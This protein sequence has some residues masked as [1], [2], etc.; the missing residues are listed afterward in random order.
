MKEMIYMDNAATTPVA[1]SV[2]RRMSK[3][4]RDKF[5]NPSSLY[6]SANT[7]RKEGLK[8]SRKRIADFLGVE[9]DEIVFT[10]GATESDNLAIKGV[11]LNLD[12]PGHFI[13]TE[14]EHHAVLHSFEWLE[15]QGHEV[16]YLEVNEDGLVD[17]DNLR[18]ELRDDTALVSIMYANNEIGTVEP[19]EELAEISDQNGTLFHT[20]A[21][22][23]YG[24]FPLDL[25]NVDML[26]ASGH[27]IYGPKG[28]GLLYRRKGVK[29]EPLIH[30]GG[31]ENGLRSGTENV[32]GIV[33]LARATELMDEEMDE[34]PERQR[35]LRN[36]IIEEISK[37]PDTVLNGPRENRLSNN[38]NFSFQGIEGES[39][40]MKLDNKN[41]AA[42]TGSAC[43]SPTL[44]PS[45]V[46]LAINLPMSLAHG[47]LRLT[48]GRETTRE[49]VDYLLEVLPGIV[50]DLR[51]ASPL[52]N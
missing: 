30:G 8:W 11:A 35:Q 49:G 26:S 31:H 25:D 44:E 7:A 51:R 45:H 20:D 36:R 42:S 38:A 6:S 9:S 48:L 23:A 1:E 41:I 46:L 39:I 14:I 27:K 33:G 16:T 15:D 17:P 32:P 19:V 10:S 40:V 18:E 52:A 43:S 28:V 12:E 29:L 50:E 2:K 5:G 34:E 21:V 24:K 22:Q 4:F 3:F 47:S 13:T 37:I